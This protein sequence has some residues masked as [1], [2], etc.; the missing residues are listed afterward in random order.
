MGFVNLPGNID[1][2]VK[3]NLLFADSYVD[4]VWFDITQPA[5]PAVAGRLEHAF[6][7]VLPPSDN[8]Y[9][10][11]ELD[12]SKGV[13]IGWKVKTITEKR[14]HDI[15]CPGCLY[16]NDGASFGAEGGSSGV[17]GM[18]GSMSRFAVHGDYL[19]AV[20]DFM[21]KVFALS[22]NDVTKGG[23]QY[24]NWNTETIF[25]YDQKLFLGTTSG[26]LI[27]D[28]ANPAVPEYLSSL[29]HVLGCDPV[30][31]QG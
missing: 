31:V 15:Y 13:V 28:I 1:L 8:Y 16:Q 23:E 12:A 27:Y 30:V 5:Q 29:N 14:P 11:T 4:L 22:G 20:T 10:M 21:L 18:T 7:D 19:Y 3:G 17:A 2:A 25:A 24:L 6:P 26:L 9:L